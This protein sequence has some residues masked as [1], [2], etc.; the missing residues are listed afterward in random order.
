MH[1]SSYPLTSQ[2]L[3]HEEFTLHSSF[4]DLN[5]NISAT[6]QMHITKI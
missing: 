6:S 3:S 4:L 1:Q 2:L 5:F